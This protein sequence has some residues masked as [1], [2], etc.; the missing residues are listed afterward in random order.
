MTRSRLFACGA[1]LLVFAGCATPPR[2]PAALA[3]FKAVNDPLEPLNRKTFAFNQRVD[4]IVL[5]PIAKGYRW[6]I[7]PAGRDGIRNFIRN[8]HEPIVLVNNLLQGELKRAGTTVGRFVANSTLGLA[9]VMDFAGRHGLK[10]QTGDFGQ[11]LYVWG[12]HEGPYLVLPVMGPSSPR[13]AVGM[14]ADLFTNPFLYL[15]PHFKYKTSF[16]VSEAAINGID[17][18]SRNID[19]LDE[20]QRETVDFY[21]ALRSLYRQNRAADLRHGELPPAPKVEDLYNDPGD[22][23]PAG[24]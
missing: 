17:E 14:G 10:Q 5:K 6:A 13:D 9:G 23:S 16:S 7:P 12:V 11:T 20:V 8:L 24:H 21:A 15:T 1:L 4:R 18:R 2:D 19:S 3:A 22:P